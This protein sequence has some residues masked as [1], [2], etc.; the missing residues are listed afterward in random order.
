MG[1]FKYVRQKRKL[2]DGVGPLLNGESELV[3]ED[4]RK[5]Q[6][7]IAYFASVFSPKKKKGQEK[8]TCDWTTSEVTTVNKEERMQIRISK[9]Q[10]REF[11]SEGPDTMHLKVLKIFTT[12]G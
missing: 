11:K 12:H 3:I 7:L 10:I 1:F 6:L 9:V 2:R 8:K 5:A 4:E